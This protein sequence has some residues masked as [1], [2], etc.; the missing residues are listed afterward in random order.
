MV[1]GLVKAK[2]DEYADITIVNTCIVTRKASYQSRQA[3]RKS[4]REN[5]DSITAAVGCYAQVFPDELLSIRGLDMAVGNTEKSRLPELLFEAEKPRSSCLISKDFKESEKFDSLPI[6]EFSNRTRAFL[7]IQDGCDSFCSYCI[8]PFARGPLRSLD[9]TRVINNIKDLCERGY[10]EIVLTGIHLGKYG[11]D[12]QQGNGLK[13]LLVRIGKE[14][15]PLRIRLS[16]L[17][18]KEIDHELISM[19]ASEE[20]ICRHL[21]Q[22]K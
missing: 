8:V 22:I 9:Q 19:M 2:E 15:V 21:M 5:P 16:S 10:K 6:K 12:L 1:K 14:K 20:W 17:E 4:L 3:I 18:P 13:D 11:I 7:K